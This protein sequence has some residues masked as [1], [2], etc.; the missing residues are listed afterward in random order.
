MSFGS[1]QASESIIAGAA[2]FGGVPS[3]LC[4]TADSKWVTGADLGSVADKG[5]T[6]RRYRPKTGRTRQR[7][8]TVETE[9]LAGNP[10]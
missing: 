4:G 10:A 6:S 2:A 7:P 1:S 9:S 5:V 3:P 8:L